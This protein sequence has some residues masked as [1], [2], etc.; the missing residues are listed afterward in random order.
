MSYRILLLL[1]AAVPSA[2]AALGVIK[3]TVVTSDG[4]PLSLATVTLHPIPGSGVNSGTMKTD[5]FGAFIFWKIEP[6]AYLLS[7]TRPNFLPAQCGQL[8]WNSAGKPLILPDNGTVSVSIT[9]HRYGAITGR[10]IDENGIGIPNNEVLA[11]RDTQPPQ[12]AGK[13]YADDYGRYRIYGM[14]PGMYL[15][16]SGPQRVDGADFVPTFAPGTQELMHA[17]RV[18]VLIDLETSGFD[19]QPEQGR[20]FDVSAEI[21]SNAE[22]DQPQVTLAGETG[23]QLK[24]GTSLKFDPLP[25]GQ[26][27]IYANASCDVPGMPLIGAYLKFT[28]TKDETI[29]VPMQAVA[30]IS[31]SYSVDGSYAIPRGAKLPLL[32]RPVDMAGPGESKSLGN[33]PRDPLLPAGRWELLLE[34]GGG[35]AVMD[36]SAPQLAGSDPRPPAHP[37]AWNEVVAGAR[38]RSFIHYSLSANAGALLGVVK[39]GNDPVVGAPVYL[40]SYDPN[41]H[42]R[43]TELRIL[44]TDSHGNYEFGGLSPGT[45]RVLS[46]FE[47]SSP[48]T[49]VMDT[50]H[51]TTVRI[52]RAQKHNEDLQLYVIQ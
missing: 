2:S 24:Q 31:I 8:R 40:E 14:L 33:A 27:E 1:L 11:F 15:V 44:T 17:R 34:G 42:K 3:G 45:Y 36:V 35:L 37:D 38:N 4:E 28:V 19:L 32:G 12:L 26:Y 6:G 52:E 7:A 51:A 23:R 50:S 13:A 22:C 10:V 9:M 47:Y 41:E 46:T 39:D 30:R 21:I 43:L 29:A 18:Q 20:L 5:H 16:K 25:K 48:D 49:E